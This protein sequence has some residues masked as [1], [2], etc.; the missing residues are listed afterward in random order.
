M[1]TEITRK[2]GFQTRGQYES[3]VR[4]LLMDDA[5]TLEFLKSLFGTLAGDLAST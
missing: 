3:A 2:L 4:R 5:V 1:L